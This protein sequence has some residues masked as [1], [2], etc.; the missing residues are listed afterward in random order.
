MASVDDRRIASPSASTAKGPI[1]F[2]EFM[3]LAL[4]ER[5]TGFF[6]RGGGAGRAGRDFV[7]S[8]EV[9]PLFGAVVAAC[10]RRVVA[11]ARARPIRSWWS[12]PA[13][14]RGRSRPTCCAPR[15]RARGAAVRARRAL[16]DAARRAARAARARAA[17]RGARPVH[18]VADDAPSPGRRAAARSS[19]R[20]TTCP[21]SP[22]RGRARQRAVRQPRRSDSSSAPTAA[23]S[24]CGSGVDG[25][26]LRRGA[27]ARAPPTWRR[28][29]PS[30]REGA[31]AGGARIPV[32][33][34]PARWLERVRGP[35]CVA[36]T[37]CSS[38]TSTTATSSRA[39]GQ[40]GVAAHVPRRTT[41]RRSRSTT[42]GSQD[43]TC[44]VA[45]RV[46][47]AATPTGWGFRSRVEHA[48]GRVARRHGIAELV[49]EGGAMWQAA[50]ATRRPR[51]LAGRSR[52]VEAAALTDP[53][54]LGAHRVLVLRRPRA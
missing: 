46:R 8:P 17:R 21:P 49:A 4:Y 41:R 25:D 20:S 38:T 16:A 28:G 11:R 31:V 6:T 24:R 50:R 19:P 23:G 14:G 32:P 9:G 45:A 47:C 3:E 36:A 42:P 12:K 40:A 44:D 15:R 10:A 39:A 43:I 22:S 52:G 48:A 30:W 18:R 51:A 53:G 5:P 37:S 29:G 33:T 13:P 54:G 26:A 1:P 27:R 34:R 2:D 7:T 35:C